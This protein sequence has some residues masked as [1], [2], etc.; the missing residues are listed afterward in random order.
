TEH[1]QT[2]KRYGRARQTKDRREQK[3]DEDIACV[4]ERHRIAGRPTQRSSADGGLRHGC[5]GD[6]ER[7]RDL[8]QII[9]TC[10][11]ITDPEVEQ[12]R[13]EKRPW[14]SGCSGDER[15][16]DGNASG[17]ENRGRVPG[18]GGKEETKPASDDIGKRQ[19]RVEQQPPCREPKYG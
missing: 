18:R 8:R 1:P 14:Q 13:A 5:G 3:K 17:N 15:R 4:V 7:S 12:E 6:D 16:G 10:D 9:P 2:D 19:C 11:Q